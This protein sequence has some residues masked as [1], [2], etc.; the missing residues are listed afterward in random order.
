MAAEGTL[1]RIQFNTIDTAADE[2][3]LHQIL[4]LPHIARP[5]ILAQPIQRGCGKCPIRKLVLA[6]KIIQVIVEEVRNI[7]TMLPQWG[8]LERRNIKQVVEVAAK[9]L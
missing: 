1:H 7:L 8:N 4:K 3:P 5:A 9:R 2:Q 6:D